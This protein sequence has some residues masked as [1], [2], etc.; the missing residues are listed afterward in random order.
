MRLVRFTRSPEASMASPSDDRGLWDPWIDGG[1]PVRAPMPRR[2]HSGFFAVFLIVML[3]GSLSALFLSELT[4][5]I[6]TPPAIEPPHFITSNTPIQTPEEIVHVPQGIVWSLAFSPDGRTLASG[7]GSWDKPNVIT[8]WD[9][10]TRKLEPGIP[11]GDQPVDALQEGSTL[12][13]RFLLAGH[14]QTI[15]GLTFSPDG[16][17][18]ASAGYDGVV[19]LWDVQRGAERVLFPGPRDTVACAAFSPDGETLA[20]GEG[21]PRT[22]GPFAILLWSLAEH[23][24][25]GRILGLK[26]A[27]VS[28]AFS[29]DGRTL[30]S[31]GNLVTAEL[32]DAESGAHKATLHGHYL[33]IS[34]VAFSTDGKVLATE[35]NDG[36]VRLWDVASALPLASWQ[37]AAKPTFSPVGNFLAVARSTTEG[38][39]IQLREVATGKVRAMFPETARTLAFSPDGLL[40]ATAPTND[41]RG[42]IHLWSVRRWLGVEAERA[43]PSPQ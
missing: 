13:E 24:E 23:R 7:A 39:Q 40:L 28:L 8:L 37:Y 6:P 1:Q 42:E 41:D 2:L 34:H 38:M 27:P 22:E 32:W 18:L 17:T 36:Y 11:R 9:V 5:P 30:A 12:K 15:T 20:V 4:Q 35:G 29:P 33:P 25:R 10:N 43:G 26:R 19:K 31:A 21:D 14:S 16:K 3:I